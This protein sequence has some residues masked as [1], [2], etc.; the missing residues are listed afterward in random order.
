M[1]E[2]ALGVD[3]GGSHIA[4]AIVDINKKILVS[5]TKTKTGLDSKQDAFTILNIWVDCIKKCLQ[6]FD[7]FP[8]K[9]I[10]ISMPGPSNY[11]Y[12]ISE[13]H[14]CNKYDNLY[15]V[16]IRTYLYSKL[17]NWV[18]H[19][20]KITFI[21]DANSFLLGSTWS[22]EHKGTNIT[23]ITL[24]TGIGSGFMQDGKVVTNAGNI[25]KNGDVYN[26]PF[27]N[28]RAEDWI[29][30]QWFLDSYKNLFGVN[31]KNVK[32]IADHAVKSIK[33]QNIFNDFGANLG[34]FL[35]PILKDFNTTS[36]V[37]GGN[38][39]KSYSLFK[40]SFE[41]CFQGN[42]PTI[43]L[44]EDTENSAILGAVKDLI[45]RAETVYKPRLTQQHLMPIKYE[46]NERQ[47]TYNIYPSFEIENG[48]INV[49]FESLAKEI[50]NYKSIC[51][52]GFIGVDWVSFIEKLTFALEDLNIP[53]VVYSTLCVFKNEEE[54]DRLTK[55]F[56]G[57]DDPV[58]GK[59]FPGEIS[60]FID[61]KKLDM[62]SQAP[63]CLS[64][65]YGTGAALSQSDSKVLYIDV[66]KNEIQY[67][68][69]AG[70]VLNI[71]LKNILPTK[72]QYK[73]MFFV[74]WPALNKH[75][76]SLLNKI[77][78]IIDGQYIDNISWCNG[79][80][81]YNGLQGLSKNAFRV[82]PWFE[83]GVWG[84]D[85]IKNN[86]KGLNKNVVNYA[87]S[88]EFIAPENGVILSKN[89]I[90]LEVSLDMLM[91]YDNKAILGEAAQTFKT[92]FP[93]RF[94]FLDT[95]NGDNLSLQCHPKPDFIRKEFFEKFTQ[96]ET[97]Y[98]L[99]AAQ[100]A[101]VYL[102]F[103]GNIDKKEFHQA[104]LKS[105]SDS[106]IMDVEKYVQVHPAK[107]HDLFLIPHGTIHCS[108]KNGLVL[109]I[110][111]T[112]Y[113]YTFKMY[114][115]MRKD[116]DGNP[117]PLNIARAMQNLNFECKGAK[118]REEYISKQTIIK[119]G[120]NW[121]IIQLSTHPLHFYEIYRLEF[122]NRI[123]MKTNG[124]CHILNLVEGSKI[125]IITGNR[126]MVIR[127][128]E[129]FVVPADAQKYQLIN[130]GN[131]KAKVIQSYVKPEFCNYEL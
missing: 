54:I 32:E 17:Q 60:D 22:N 33:A 90:R 102:G 27:K 21:N 94:D 29:S 114:D 12:G 129:T 108:G 48:L 63:N 95:F 5:G 66:P 73:R 128:A 78:Y 131:I 20:N 58:F 98:M 9:G 75:K 107:K 123:D 47:E 42:L 50:S 37:F 7:Q 112:P 124:Q 97:Y 91:Y 18:D 85:W 118:V 121:K 106:T 34:A 65:F 82:R 15:G 93:I 101:N 89:G 8:I 103:Q 109:E 16:D 61:L 14:G 86:I 64:I 23:A 19:Y 80:T 53:I 70:Q 68:S 127:Y 113:I 40:N 119:Q 49:G 51:I 105:N 26:L 69:R 24:G 38:I 39:I 122:E 28:K 35:A 99:D 46:I 115:W 44:A 62:I 56:L 10:G 55:P 57:G 41:N 45:S 36:L 72:E 3:I 1:N 31:A 59:L 11:Q 79:T 43:H 76:Q 71:G 52:D 125:K 13:I 111:S 92:D 96:D 30:T 81:L 126:T 116:L 117:R 25:P 110:S 87:W 2:F 104:L 100:D 83:P 67:R 77:D 84:G 4:A 88:F 130:I 74:D 6:N 120:N